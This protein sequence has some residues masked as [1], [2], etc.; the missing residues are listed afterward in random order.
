MKT[1][2]IEFA[3]FAPYNE[4]VE[5]M[6]SWNDFKSE[7]MVKNDV[8]WWVTNVDLPDG[9]HQYKFRVKSRSFFARDQMLDIFDPY[10]LSVTEDKFERSIVEVRNGTRLWVEYEWKHDDVPLPANG[11]L[12]MYELHVGDFHCKRN[13]KTRCGTFNDVIA[14]LDYLAE[15]GVNCVELLPVKE[16]PNPGW[17]YSLRSL[18]AV[19]NS[20]GRPEDLCRLVDECHARGIRVII[21]G[22]YNHAE[23]EAPLT[24]IDYAYWFHENNPD[25]PHMQWGPKFNYHLYDEKL[26]I[27]PARKYV[28][29]SIK[30]WVEK[31]HID[32]IR[33]DATTAI[34]DFDVMRELADAGYGK[35]NGLKHFLTVAE[36]IPEDP[37]ITGRERGAP[38]DA[39]WHDC[40]GRHLQ[41]IC[42]LQEQAGNH[43][44]DLDGL[45][46]KLDVKTNGY[47][48][49]ERIVNF[50]G[51]HD[52]KRPM[53]IIGDDGKIFDEAAFRRMKVG[54]ALLL[55]S[56]GL[57]MLWMGEEFGFPADKSLEPRPL[58]WSLL[59]NANNSD[60]LRYHQR[61]IK[62]RKETPALQGETFEVVLKDPGR[63]L[64]AFKRWNAEGN[65]IVIVVNLRDEPAG[66]FTIQDCGLEDGVWHEFVGHCDIDIKDGKFS[67]DLDRSEVKIYQKK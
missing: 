47:E 54:I 53:T 36:H 58:N 51:N 21:D 63:G 5:I 44:F 38:M 19:E 31:F 52:Y 7:P 34:K 4:I 65:V 20:Y 6:G 60:L 40:L 29:D 13:D 62:L 1:G 66:D 16:F 30:F 22:V 28:T 9:Q 32:G 56:P 24:K 43:P 49:P 67:D 48:K 10:C 15:L 23:Q 12:V 50:L 55:T 57:P 33:F 35:V 45:I 46:Q 18:F 26:K 61:L 64:L 37:A 25:P 14:K 17:G 8:G 59:N 42:C 2:K 41:A 27:F 39:A 3:L 11:Q